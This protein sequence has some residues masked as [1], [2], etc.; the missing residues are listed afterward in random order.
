MPIHI[1]AVGEFPNAETQHRHLAVKQSNRLP[2]HRADRKRIG[3]FAMHQMRAKYFRVG[4]R[5]FKRITKATRHGFKRQ[6]FH[7]HIQRA[8]LKRVKPAQIIQPHDVIGM[9]MG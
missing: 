6:F 1:G 5:F 9:P 8:V 2:G 4:S 7:P 3:D